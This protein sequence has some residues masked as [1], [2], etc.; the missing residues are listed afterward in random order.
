MN[1]H[2]QRLLHEALL[3][4]AA[5]PDI[6]DK[7]AIIVEGQ[8]Y[9][10]TQLV[11][12]ARRLA[13]ALQAR[14]LR[15][16]DRVA[17][18][19]DN[20]WPCVVSVYATLLAGGVFLVV[21]PQTKADKLEYVLRDS[22][23][24]LLLTDAHLL[25]IFE[26]AVAEAADLLQII[27][28][29]PVPSG[30][31]IGTKPVTGFDAALE[32]GG[33]PAEAGVISLDLAA[34]IYTSGSTGN[35][36]GVMQTHQSMVFASGSLIQYLR[37]GREDRI[38]CVLP[39]AFDYGLYQL[40]MAVTMGATLVLERSFIYP[41]EIYARMRETGVTV[42]PGVP[43]IYAMLL[44]AHSRTP[45]H[46]PAVTRITNTAAALPDNFVVRL[47]EIFPNA[48]VYKMYGLTECKRV[49]YLEPELA[50]SKPGSV[51]KAIPG[52]EV[53]LLDPQGNPVPP[54]ETGILHVRGAHVML[55]YWNRPDLSEL[56]LRA[57]RLP[58]ERVLCTH[59][60]FRMDAEGFLYFVGRTD[61]I[62]KTRGEKVSPVEVENALHG[63]P[64]IREAAVVGIPD[65][66]LGQAIR[67]YIV[68]ETGASLGEKQLR[69]LCA[70][71]L[72]NFM[73]PKEIVFC[74]GLPKT[75]TGKVSKRLLLEGAQ[76]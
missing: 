3:L 41:A 13:S 2:P 69:A 71:L 8:P 66:L 74:D 19:M 60:H 70:G 23:A 24:R 4:C 42:F 14:G 31:R 58:G 35:P 28:S 5:R 64:G 56:M 53:Y 46:F 20:T 10:Y 72:E 1:Q 18:Y 37:L 55:G 67:A 63:I 51:G 36:K 73:V 57:G 22:G 25:N 26:P 9:T 15:R 50:D 32:E 76:K 40:I 54:G 17:I 16:G 21:N 45:L 43:T 59:D 49:C 7:A 68:L 11:D 47:R 75:A 27:M 38:L 29:G 34:L 6:A 12:A 30:G 33:T 65:E 39:L 62:I 52:T 44:S 48:L 61:D